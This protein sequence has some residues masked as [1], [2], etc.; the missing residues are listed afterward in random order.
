[1][2]LP[3]PPK[4]IDGLKVSTNGRCGPS[5]NNTRCTGTSCCSSSSWCGGEQG[6]RSA[7]CNNNQKGIAS[8]KYDGG[9]NVAPIITKTAPKPTTTS[10]STTADPTCEFIPWGPDR[11]AC[12][13]RC[14]NKQDRAYWG[15]ATHCTLNK[16]RDICDNC[17]TTRCQ[18]VPQG[19]DTEDRCNAFTNKI[20]CKYKENCK[21]D[22]Y[23]LTCNSVPEPDER[24]T[25]NHPPKQLISVI[26]GEDLTIVWKSK[27][28][29]LYPN[30]GFLVRYLKTFNP[31]EG[32]K[33]QYVE[34]SEN[35]KYKIVL[36]DLDFEEYTISISAINTVGIGE[37]SNIV[38][39]TPIKG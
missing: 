24:I 12:V 18:W 1:M 5:H 22:P 38:K 11:E 8:G 17:N 23:N 37:R 4:Y 28:N 9:S 2:P 10:T 21:W 31:H 7:W 15:G 25:V 36:K 3:P 34:Q 20:S 6:K 35:N 19:I 27:D 33:L 39:I 30:N 32:L 13:N 29:S 14:R 16:C 26:S